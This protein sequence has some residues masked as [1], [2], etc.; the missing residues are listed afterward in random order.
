MRIIDYEA[1]Y[2]CGALRSVTFQEGST[3]AEIGGS[4]FVGTGLE[5][6]EV[7]RG[8]TTIGDN[9]FKSCRDL[10]KVVFQEGSALQEIKNG[11]FENTWLEEFIVP[12]NVTVIGC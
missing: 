5:A 3:L 10:K 6:M 8:V 1:F 12:K 9:A 4:S 7:P 2:E 11:C